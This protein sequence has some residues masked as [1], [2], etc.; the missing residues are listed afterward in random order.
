MTISASSE[1]PEEVS[2]NIN[3]ESSLETTS[4]I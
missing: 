4:F 2:K 1:S 3:S